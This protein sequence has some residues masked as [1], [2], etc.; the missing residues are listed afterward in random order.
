MLGAWVLRACYKTAN[1]SY[2]SHANAKLTNPVLNELREVAKILNP[3]KNRGFY[4]R[5]DLVRYYEAHG[6]K[7]I[8]AI[9]ATKSAEAELAKHFEAYEAECALNRSHG[10]QFAAKP[11]PEPAQLNPELQAPAYFC[12]TNANKALL[13]LLG[14]AGLDKAMLVRLEKAGVLR[15]RAPQETPWHIAVPYSQIARAYKKG[16]LTALQVAEWCGL[17]EVPKKAQAA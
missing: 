8:D 5:G 1:F 3:Q 15:R 6:Y 11:L 16:V 12:L 13:V 7:E 2:L 10:N 14:E 9:L 17:T 4:V